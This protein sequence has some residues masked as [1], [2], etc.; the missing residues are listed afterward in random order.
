MYLLVTI[1][2]LVL[3][4]AGLFAPSTQTRHS[5][6]THKV[7][8]SRPVPNGGQPPPP[9]CDPAVQDCSGGGGYTN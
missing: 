9:I 3:S 4:S 1:L 6:T 7:S 8:V 5:S 2:S